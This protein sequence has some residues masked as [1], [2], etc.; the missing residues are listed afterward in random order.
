MEKFRQLRRLMPYPFGAHPH[1]KMS[2]KLT[3]CEDSEDLL[4]AAGE[5]CTSPCV[6]TRHSIL[7]GHLPCQMSPSFLVI[8]SSVEET[9][10]VKIHVHRN[11]LLL[12][13]IPA[14]EMRLSKRDPDTS[15][16]SWD[17]DTLSAHHGICESAASHVVEAVAGSRRA[18]VRLSHVC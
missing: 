18:V 5:A 14:G 13:I 15:R 6:H 16:A 2:Y 11:A 1:V 7:S 8:H 12:L 9:A 3:D 17:G 10:F 4:L